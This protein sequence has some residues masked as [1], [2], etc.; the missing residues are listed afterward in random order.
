MSNAGGAK[1]K[2]GDGKNA[3]DWGK[4]LSGVGAVIGAIAALITALYLAGFIKPNDPD[5]PTSTR[6]AQALTETPPTPSEVPATHTRTPIT[7]S[8]TATIPTVGGTWTSNGPF[9]VYV[10]EVAVSPDFAE[11]LTV[12]VADWY[13]PGYRSTDGGKTWQEV[14][15]LGA[16]RVF[17]FSSD[18]Y[19]DQTIYAG[20]LGAVMRSTD[21]GHTWEE[22]LT[23]DDYMTGASSRLV[24]Y[25]ESNY[26]KQLYRSVDGGQTWTAVGPKISE[27]GG[28]GIRVGAVSPGFDD[29]A[30]FA[31]TTRGV[32]RS[33]DGGGSWQ[34]VGPEMGQEDSSME[35]QMAIS[36]DYATD[37]TLMVIASGRAWKSTDGGD[38]W[39]LIHNAIAGKVTAIAFSPDYRSNGAI[40]VGFAG[41]GVFRVTNNEQ[42][43]TALG[44]GHGNKN[45]STLVITTG[46]SPTLFA[47]TFDGVWQIGLNDLEP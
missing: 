35:P 26:Q 47:G 29:M 22:V 11:D 13:S 44:N 20:T 7:P 18:Y 38:T 45:V 33:T 9:G 1:D 32:Y 6:I 24:D 14:S 2:S 8:S 10:R 31:S 5:E 34:N 28:Y 41:D 17:W 30:V 12:Y 15:A 16:V 39:H 37:R 36:P 4:I 19:F 40:Y 42:Y 3:P 43:W 27:E 21:R 23:G 25:V 46:T